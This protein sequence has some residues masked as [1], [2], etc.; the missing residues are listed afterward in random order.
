MSSS[1]WFATDVTAAYDAGLVKGSAGQFMP[2]ATITRQ[3]MTVLLAKAIKLIDLQKPTKPVI[4][5]YAD[6]AQFS[7]YAQ[8]S[9]EI[10]TA[11]GL[12]EGVESEGSFYFEPAHATTREAAAKVLYGLLQAAKRIN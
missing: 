6:A 12:M 11:V 10:V 1:D 3:D 5:L 9:I 7:D 2:N 4:H 8:E